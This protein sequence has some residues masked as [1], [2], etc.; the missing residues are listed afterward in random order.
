MDKDDNNKGY[1]VYSCAKLDDFR[2]L[3]NRLV[4]I[5]SDLGKLPDTKDVMDLKQ[6]IHSLK[7]A[8]GIKETKNGEIRSKIRELAQKAEADDERLDKDIRDVYKLINDLRQDFDKDLRSMRQKWRDDIGSINN[9]IID[10]RLD[11]KSNMAQNKEL[12]AI[13]ILLFTT[14]IGFLVSWIYKTI[15]LGI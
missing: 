3:D 6:E 9:T 11:L 14:F 4:K 15:F 1:N 7:L 13:I 5:E 10:V 12:K 2:R 8:L